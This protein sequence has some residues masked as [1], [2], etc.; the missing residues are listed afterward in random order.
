LRPAP[1]DSGKLEA[2]KM[3]INETLSQRKLSARLP[4]PS[5]RVLIA[6]IAVAFL[7]LHILAGMIIQRAA[8]DRPATPQQQANPS[9]YD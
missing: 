4:A 7:F 6:T 5:E 3:S 2:M 8:A 9:S 1:F